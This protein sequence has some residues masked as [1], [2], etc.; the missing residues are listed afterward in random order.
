VRAAIFAD[1]H[2]QL[3]SLFHRDNSLHPAAWPT[4][5]DAVEV[6]SASTAGRAE[7][8]DKDLIDAV[9]NAK[10]LWMPSGPE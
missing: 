8:V 10:G 5:S 6:V 1:G 9:W 7:R 3:C 2:L 4:C